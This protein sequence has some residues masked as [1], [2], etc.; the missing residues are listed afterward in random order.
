MG[1]KQQLIWD[2]PARYLKINAA[3]YGISDKE[4]RQRVGELTEMLSLQGKLNQP[5]RKLSLGERELNCWQHC[6]NPGAFGRTDA[7]TR[8]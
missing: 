6:I 7:G 1:Q 8:R 4:Y 2:L 3:I 5:V